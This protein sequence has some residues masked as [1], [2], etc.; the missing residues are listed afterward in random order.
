MP[1][2]PILDAG[3]MRAQADELGKQVTELVARW[4]HE[5]QWPPEMTAQAMLAIVHGIC[6]KAGMSP[7]EV[8][9]RAA[10]QF[11]ACERA[12]RAATRKPK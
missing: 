6:R 9:E 12:Y 3:T 10:E 2:G 11:S 4:E 5:K 7:H 1:L 8:L